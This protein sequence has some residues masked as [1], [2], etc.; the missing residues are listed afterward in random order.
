MQRTY[1]FKVIVDADKHEDGRKAYRVHC[2]EIEEA[3]TWGD[4]RGAAMRRIHELL[5]ALVQ[6]RIERGQPIPTATQFESF[7]V[8]V[9]VTV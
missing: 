1:V 5:T 2:P 7:A 9:V 6:M 3:V 4:T 8:S